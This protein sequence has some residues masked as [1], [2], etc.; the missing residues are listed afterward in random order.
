MRCV[1]RLVNALVYYGLSLNTENLA[2]S[3]YLNFCLAGAV[4]IPAYVLCILLLNRVGRRTP[5]IVAMYLG[6]LA[7]ILSGALPQTSSGQCRLGSHPDIP[8][9]TLLYPE[10]PAI[11]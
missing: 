8:R 11:P 4:E 2:G 6:G 5:L 9:Y 7:C 10:Y 3:P 1:G